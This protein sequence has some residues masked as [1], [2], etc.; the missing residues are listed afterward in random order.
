MNDSKNK[1]N[2]LCQNIEQKDILLYIDQQIAQHFVQR[3][4]SL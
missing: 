3:R 4:E 1:Q 2:M